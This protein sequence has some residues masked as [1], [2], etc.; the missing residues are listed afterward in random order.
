[1]VT[2]I[3]YLLTLDIYYQD[4]L[5]SRVLELWSINHIWVDMEM[6]WITLEIPDAEGYGNNRKV[7]N[8]QTDE[9]SYNL[10][11]VQLKA[12]AEKRAAQISKSLL[13]EL[14]RRLL[15]RAQS[16]WF[17]TYLAAICLLNCV[18]RS[19][20]LFQ[21][22]DFEQYKVIVSENI[23]FNSILTVFV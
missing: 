19:T 8:D 14:E 9:V 22:W 12:A 10:L 4:S 3:L 18:E 7:I 13:N 17:E 21:S 5:L 11:C 20:W 15:Q 1:M 23:H 16:G 6:K 2:G